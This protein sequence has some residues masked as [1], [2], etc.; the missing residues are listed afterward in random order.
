MYRLITLSLLLSLPLNAQETIFS[1]GFENTPPG[2]I[3][4][5]ITE[6][7]V[8]AAYI[9]DVDASDANGDLLA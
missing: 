4:T 5:P 7:E 2:I 6:S 3:S 8:G 1:N 9:Y